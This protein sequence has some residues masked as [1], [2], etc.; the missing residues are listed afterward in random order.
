MVYGA[1]YYMISKSLIGLKSANIWEISSRPENIIY[2]K[3]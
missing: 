2:M 1:I 3:E